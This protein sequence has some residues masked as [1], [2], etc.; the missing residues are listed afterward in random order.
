MG[1]ISGITRRDIFDIFIN[2]IYEDFFWGKEKIYYPYY[3]YREIV[4]FLK[5]LYPLE[6]WE[7]QDPRVDNAEEEITMH[8]RNGDYPDNWIFED[9]RFQ[10]FDGEDNILLNFICEVFHPEVR[11]ENGVWERYLKK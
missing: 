9:E 8:T 6:K 4:D 5:R 2:G 1:N 3:G 7:S 10:L 11:D